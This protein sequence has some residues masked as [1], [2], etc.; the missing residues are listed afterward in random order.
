MSLNRTRSWLVACG[1]QLLF[2]WAAAA[3]ELREEEYVHH[4]GDV[5]LFAPADLSSYGRGPPRPE[6]WFFTAEGLYW[7]ISAPDRTTIGREGLAPLAS[8][9][10]GFLVQPASLDTGFISNDLGSGERLQLGLVS[11]DTGWLVGTFVLHTQTHRATGSN[12]GVTFAAPFINGISV[13][14]GFV[15]LTGP[16]GVPDFISDDL[17]NNNIFGCDGED[18]GTEN[19][20]PPPLFI[21]PFDGI[22]D[23]PAP[24]DFGD[25]VTSPVFFKE[26]HVRQTTKSWGIEA[27]RI[28]QRGAK[29]RGA[30]WEILGGARYIRFQDGFLVDGRGEVFLDDS[31]PIDVVIGVLADSRWDTNA[32]NNVVGPQIGLRYVRRNGRLALSSEGRFLAGANFQSIRQVGYIA[33][34]PRTDRSIPDPTPDLVVVRPVDPINL[35]P[36]AFSHSRDAVEFSPAVELRVDASY[37]LFRSVA[38]KVGWT[39]LYV[40]GVARSSNMIDY[41]LPTMGI[42]MNNRQEVFINGVNFGIEFNR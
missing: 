22:P 39:G 16:D 40:D 34:R 41:T 26:L 9:G 3:Q 33:N 12:A 38:L 28:W 31:V 25:L 6:G 18:L 8:D 19:D 2:V 10:E 37:Q 27:M 21:L 42:V 4:V 7:G 17:N 15:D 11:D 36:T 29:K 20:D 24:C 32:D 1:L 30:N 13:L 23:T 14:E 35:F 5:Q